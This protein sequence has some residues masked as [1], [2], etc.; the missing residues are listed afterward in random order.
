MSG[1][2]HERTYARRSTVQVLYTSE[3]QN[4]P[5]SVLLESG[6]CIE[7]DEPLS[8]YAL[9]LIKGVEENRALIDEQ[10]ESTS[11]NWTVARMPILDRTILRLATYEMLFVKDVPISVSINE[12]V[13][14]A[15]DFG[16][17]EDSPRFVN[18]VLGRI[19]KRIEAE[20]AGDGAAAAEGDKTV[21]A[22]SS[23]EPAEGIFDEISA[24]LLHPSSDKA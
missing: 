9:K 11:E 13:E 10:L 1:R 12:A 5:P 4:E 8:D 24:D 17:E 14:L 2:R 19:A 7:Q 3:I 15:K 6:R 23:F 22:T 16:G 20:K 18:G 21:E